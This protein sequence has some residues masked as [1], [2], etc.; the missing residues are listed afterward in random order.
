M[1]R[2]SMS[3]TCEGAKEEAGAGCLAW[4]GHSHDV[5]VGCHGEKDFLARCSLCYLNSIRRNDKRRTEL[6]K[7][8]STENSAGFISA[9]KT[10]KNVI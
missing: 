9:L 5:P 1:Q 10:E 2:C 7:L 4:Q 6:E 8:M 3:G